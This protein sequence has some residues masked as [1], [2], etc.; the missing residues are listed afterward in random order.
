MST[1]P[2]TAAP[3]L[4]IRA[5]PKPVKRFS[6]PA[7]AALLGSAGLVVL[8]TAMVTGSLTSG[9]AGNAPRELYS[10]QNKPTA[11]GLSALP[12]S[13]GDVRA[14]AVA[15]RLGPPL[16]GDL[17]GP[18]LR[19]EREGRIVIEDRLGAVP[20]QGPRDADH[21]A[22][23]AARLER[24]AL[25]A[26]RRSDLFFSNR[27]PDGRGAVGNGGLPV[28][29]I[30]GQIAADNPFLALGAAQSPFGASLAEDPNRQARKLDFMAGEGPD[31]AIYNPHRLQEPVSP[32]QVMAGTVIPATLLTGVNSDL[33]GQVIAQVTEP[34][35]D[36]VTG[37]FLLIPQGT[38]VMGRYDSVI[39]FGQSRALI[40]WSRLV[41]PDG[42]SLRIE[43]LPGVDARGQAG[44]SDRTDNHSLRIFSAAA[45]SSLISVGAELGEDDDE[46]IARALRDATQDGASRVGE[47][48]VRRQLN[49]QPTLTI[50]PGWRFR[51][52]VHQDLILRPYG[53][54]Q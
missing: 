9:E 50:R 26:A 54:T 48:I 2:D 27:R 11:E 14:E 29:G 12:A 4:S 10:T 42:T 43:N 30:A 28:S 45:L 51:I 34:V 46:T 52:L 6:K 37:Q 17:G 31:A 5:R 53:D 18:M 39:A 47:D 7:L 49:V 44:L 16:P 19:A 35:Y 24:E 20:V 38:R 33:P 8:L 13:Y 21:A 3:D 32:W 22:I 15:D 25:E 36:T 40:V 23:E 1:T 41:F